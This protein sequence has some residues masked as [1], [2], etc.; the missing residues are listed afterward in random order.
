M[1]ELTL[2][3]IRC[4]SS[5]L[6]LILEKSEYI[7]TSKSTNWSAIIMIL[8]AVSLFESDPISGS[9]KVHTKYVNRNANVVIIAPK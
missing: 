9:T 6:Y 7:M 4:S 2:F 5:L 3:V 1:P 8:G